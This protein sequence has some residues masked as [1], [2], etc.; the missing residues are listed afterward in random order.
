[1]F[2]SFLDN[3][4]RYHSDPKNVGFFNTNSATGNIPKAG[5][6]HAAESLRR[7]AIKVY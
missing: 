5:N 6:F 4:R 1:M 7:K 3:T 2:S